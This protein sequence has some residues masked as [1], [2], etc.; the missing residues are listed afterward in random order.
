[1]RRNL[2]LAAAAC[3]VLLAGWIGWHASTAAIAAP[4]P[5]PETH[6]F[7]IEYQRAHGGA[8]PLLW[9]NLYEKTEPAIAEKMLRHQLQ[10]AVD[11]YRPAED[12]LA[13]AWDSEK[14]VLG[15]QLVYDVTSKKISTMSDRKKSK[16]G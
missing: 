10:F 5:S 4:D 13:T 6:L 9:L 16:K 14:N 2:K 1:M 12:V 8:S 3:V 11:H 15:E 7:R